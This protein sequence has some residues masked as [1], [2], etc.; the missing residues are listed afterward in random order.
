MPLYG[1]LN[2]VV[3]AEVAGHR[4]KRL[5]DS[6]GGDP[7]GAPAVMQIARR[8]DDRYR[9]L[10]QKQGRRR[11]CLSDQ[12]RCP[13][14]FRGPCPKRRQPRPRGTRTRFWRIAAQRLAIG[15]GACR[16]GF[17]PVIFLSQYMT[18]G[19]ARPKLPDLAK[20]A[21][22]IARRS[23]RC[24]SRRMLGLRKPRSAQRLPR[25]KNHSFL[26][27]CFGGLA[28]SGGE[29]HGFPSPPH[30]GFGF[31][32]VWTLS[33]VECALPAFARVSTK[34]SPDINGHS[35]KD[36][37]Q[38]EPLKPGLSGPSLAEVDKVPTE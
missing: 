10:S 29:T 34:K 4:L 38:N 2:T 32:V 8:T 7:V 5:I 23:E 30:N 27:I 16:I 26:T 28:V 9:D 33:S 3:P 17:Q 13:G 19:K 6:F 1:P 31:I 12:G 20:D 35:H 37:H 11:G 36:H 24:P 15:V 14:P 21:R 25:P 18:V 22:S